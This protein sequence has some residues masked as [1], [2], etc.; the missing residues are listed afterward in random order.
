MAE[1][2]LIDEDENKD[3]K[4]RFIIH[5]DGEKELLVEGRE[6]ETA[7]EVYFDVPEITEDNE[8]EVVMTPEQL[9]ARK[10]KLEEEK[11][12]R[13]L[14]AVEMLDKAK[15][16]VNSGRYATALEY[17]EQAEELDPEN[18]E[19][20]ITRL[21]AYTRNYTDYAQITDAAKSA[22]KIALYASK[23]SKT[24]IFNKTASVLE[25]NIT[26]L[27]NRVNA[28][29]NENEQKKKER[30]V[31]FL[32]SRNL[33]LI[34]LAAAFAAFAGFGFGAIYSIV[35]IS[36][37]PT[38]KFLIL[39]CVLGG[40]ALVAFAAVAVALRM[41]NI[42]L[43]RLRMNRRNTTTNLGREMLEEQEKLK[44]FIAVQSALKGDQ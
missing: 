14:K 23:E 13:A 5:D 33:A 15:K 2:R 4:Y 27:R 37:V 22:D 25:S 19:I 30:A 8:E 38:N 36:S 32:R 29:N 39:A 3:K 44:A 12:E 28:L 1:E 10:A 11:K 6:E 35:N 24:D 7:E 42:A 16:D 31:T 18:G 17:L 20:Y 41:L 21:A 43:R 9:A 34:I 26:A 40:L